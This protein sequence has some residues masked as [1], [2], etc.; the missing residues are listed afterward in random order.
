MRDYLPKGIDEFSRWLA[1]FGA[2]IY[3]YY[4]VVG[5]T[6]LEAVTFVADSERFPLEVNA[7][8]EAQN[9]YRAA[10]AVRD[11]DRADTIEPR[12]RPFVQRIQ[13]HPGM[14]DKIRRDLGITVPND[15]PTALSEVDIEQ[16]GAPL[17]VADVSQTKRAILKFGPNPLKQRKN[18]LPG[19][20]RGVRL[21]YYLGSGP[22]PNEKDWVFLDD[23]NRSPYANVAMNAQPITITYRAAYIDRQNRTG[24]FSTPVTVTINP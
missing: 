21:W 1:N 9:A 16:A 17:L 6:P 2:Q 15:K 20:M 14:T 23:A 8:I 24:A 5:A 10:M 11:E 22:P 7:V 3:I 13:H 4:P 12:L 19:G 18:A